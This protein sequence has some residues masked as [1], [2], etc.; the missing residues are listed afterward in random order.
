MTQ[1]RDERQGLRPGFRVLARWSDDEFDAFRAALRSAAP[2]VYVRDLASRTASAA[3]TVAASDI[4][5]VLELC[6]SFLTTSQQEPAETPEALLERLRPSIEATGELDPKA[7]R[8]RVLPRLLETILEPA[9]DR[10][11]RARRTYLRHEHVFDDAFVTTDVR[12]IFDEDGTA[13]HTLISHTIGIR[14]TRRDEQPETLFV[15]VDPRDLQRLKT[16]LDR[17]EREAETIRAGGLRETTV[18][19]IDL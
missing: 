12:P 9:L 15:A 8:D 16:V 3:T 4:T 2:A 14:Y 7:L 17:A 10:T 6:D 11:Q 19:D 1:E 18:L 13:N 5:A